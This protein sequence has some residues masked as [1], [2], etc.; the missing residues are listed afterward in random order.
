M[1]SILDL[2]GFGT[3]SQISL[4][5]PAVES[6]HNLDFSRAIV[7][8]PSPLIMF[9]VI[10][11]RFSLKKLLINYGVDLTHSV[12]Y[13]PFHNDRL[14]GKPSA[15]YHD[16]TDRLYCFSES[17]SYTAYHAL[18]ILYNYD[19]SQIFND[20]W[21]GFSLSERDE[22]LNRHDLTPQTDCSNVISRH[23]TN[24][25][26]FSQGRVT[27]TQMKNGLYRLF[28]MSY[29]ETK[30]ESEVLQHVNQC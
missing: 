18:K 2:E 12:I 23:S 27:Y 24:L 9:E 11:K 22:I 17:K 16:D 29:S 19:M 14:T 8:K 15:K 5:D 30:S 10:N 25:K 21:K 20:I 13:C 7:Q 26:A 28:L 3:F 6:S 4:D 1:S